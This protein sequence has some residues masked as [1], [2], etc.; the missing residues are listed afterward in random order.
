MILIGIDPGLSGAL[1]LLDSEHGIVEIVDM[2]VFKVVVSGKDRSRLDLAGLR[3]LLAGWK[4]WEPQLVIVEDV[5]D[6]PK[7]SGMFSFGYVKGAIEATCMCLGL[8]V[9]RIAPQRWK[10]ALRVGVADDE[11]LQ[12]ADWLFPGEG[13]RWR[14]PRGGKLHDRAEAAM[15]AKYG[16][17][18]FEDLTNPQA[19]KK[20][21]KE[22][23]A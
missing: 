1:C 5:A 10:K 3:N 7:Q 16:A 22:L 20:R 19:H 14:G 13:Q 18:Y 6:R 21:R 2:P 23:M 15:L 4:A 17:M 8:H 9:E 11:I 12:R